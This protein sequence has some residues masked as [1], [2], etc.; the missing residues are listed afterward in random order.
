M[1]AFDADFALSRGVRDYPALVDALRTGDL[2]KIIRWELPAYYCCVVPS[3]QIMG[4]SGLSLEQLTDIVWAMS[5]RMQYN[6]WHVIP[7]NLPK[8]TVAQPRDFFAPQT[9]PDIAENMDYFH[10][11]HVVGG[12][13]HTLRSPERVTVAGHAFSSLTDLRL[14]RTR[15]VPF[16]PA[17]LGAVIRIARFLADCLEELAAFCSTGDGAT[18]TSFDSPWHRQRT[19]AKGKTL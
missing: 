16:T 4:H 8:E 17:E 6:T 18:I 7:G 5:G 2:S 1:E 10:R 11:G 12:V 19:L 9:L 15:D 13:K 3:R 14:V